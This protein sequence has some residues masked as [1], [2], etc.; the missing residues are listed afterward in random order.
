MEPEDGGKKVADSLI[1]QVSINDNMIV[2]I[3]SYVM[4]QAAEYHVASEIPDDPF[5]CVRVRFFRGVDGCKGH[6]FHLLCSNIF[7]SL[8]KAAFF[9]RWTVGR[10]SLTRRA[11]SPSVSSAK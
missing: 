1:P 7:R 5:D 11:T 2:S 4:G 9:R 3:G 10:L 8:S 6:P